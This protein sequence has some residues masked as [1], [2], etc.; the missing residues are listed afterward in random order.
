[1]NLQKTLILTVLV[2]FVVVSLNWSQNTRPNILWLTI[3]D[4]SP[5]LG[6]YGYSDAKTP[7]LDSLASRGVLYKNAFVTAPVCAVARSAI[8]TGTMSSTQGTHHM[9]NAA[10]L[11]KEIKTY[12]QLMRE[13]GYFT[14]NPGQKG[15]Y[16]GLAEGPEIWDKFYPAT[17]DYTDRPNKTKP[18]MHV[19]NEGMGC[20]HESCNSDKNQT[21]YP[22]PQKLTSFPPYYPDTPK[23]RKFWAQYY[24]NV[25]GV[26]KNVLKKLQ[27]LKASGEDTNTIV[28][29]YSDHG[30]GLPRA[31]R[32]VYESG[33]RIPLIVLV[34]PK[35]QHLMPYAPGTKTD[36][37]VTSL[38]I[39]ATA[40][41][42]AGVP[43]PEYMQ[44]RAF[45]GKN[46]TP[47]RKYVY[48][49][50]DRMDER[51]EIIRTV[52]DSR[53]KYIR[54]YEYWKPHL[55]FNHYAELNPWS[56]ILEEIRRVGS[57]A[58]PPPSIQWYFQSKTV[59]ELYDMQSDP[60]EMVDIARDP[61][62][63]DK[64][65]ELR[66]EHL[67]WRKESRDL[68]AIPEGVLLERKKGGGFNGEYDYGKNKTSEIE[69]AWNMLDSLHLYTAE[70]LSKS[71]THS[72]L[73]VRFW[74]AIGLGNLKVL[75]SKDIQALKSAL[76]DPSF[77]VNLAA[78]RSLLYHQESLEA[79]SVIKKGLAHSDGTVRLLAVNYADELGNKVSSIQ[80]EIKAVKEFRDATAV[81]TRTIETISEPPLSFSI[82]IL[83]CSNS[84]YTEYFANRTA[85]DDRLCKTSAVE[86]LNLPLINSINIQTGPGRIRVYIPG[87]DRYE[88]EIKNLLGEF[89]VRHVTITNNTD[90]IQL[91]FIQGLG[92]LT[93]YGQNFKISKKIFLGQSGR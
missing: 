26:D 91:P 86:N 14:T 85:D 64:L 54:N 22:D 59:E 13:A 71:L 57:E 43:I 48:G 49:H 83:G 50:R 6:S 61:K 72:D 81:A 29:I 53:Y 9:R 60:H 24:A 87:Q 17:E 93:I 44:G 90:W 46:L 55:Q 63:R 33:L 73:V 38:D 41:H 80:P 77:W 25:N 4:M 62:Y 56:G 39:T 89:L 37:L 65:I 19:D 36:E 18:F 82:P 40:L 76:S 2:L 10:T 79:L 23:A 30:A 35:W 66:N 27:Y 15:D 58:N 69:A 42:L 8:L 7:V 12:P 31:K 1:M 3:E 78:A 52:R 74:A 20:M 88:L 21:V 11:G 47:Q 92:I 5:H 84:N 75:N 32:W 70:Q 67:R 68:G 45:M 34:P 16:Q 28:F 51:Y